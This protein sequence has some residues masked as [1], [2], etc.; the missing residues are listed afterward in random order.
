MSVP[1]FNLHNEKSKL[2]LDESG[3]LKKQDIAGAYL[4][5]RHFSNNYENLF[6]LS[7]I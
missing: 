5:L 1:S 4:H 2:Q 3:M 7:M 6:Y